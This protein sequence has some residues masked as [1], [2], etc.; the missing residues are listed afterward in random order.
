MIQRTWSDAVLR[1]TT[2]GKNKKWIPLSSVA[3]EIVAR[4]ITGKFG[5]E[6]LFINPDTESHY[7]P[8]KLDYLWRQAGAIVTLYEGTRHS[9]CT[10]VAEVGDVLL[11]RDLMRHADIRTTQKYY[12]S[13]M[14]KLKDIV[15]KRR[16]IIDL[17]EIKSS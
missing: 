12:H 5:N 2:K 1:E 7:R 14:V 15:E 9:F 11:T 8:K 10:Q 6:F 3:Y 17:K 13:H 4:N 16:K